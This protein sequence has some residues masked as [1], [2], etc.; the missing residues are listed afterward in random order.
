MRFGILG[1][2]EVA[3]DHRRIMIGGR[4]PR[5]LLAAL[6]CHPNRTVSTETLLEAV[7][8]TA[9]PKTAGKNLQV[10][11]HKLR[12]VLGHERLEHHA[13]G[14]AAVVAHGELDAAEFER[15]VQHGRIADD[16]GDHDR[17]RQLY[18]RALGC[19]RGEHPL[20]GVGDTPVLQLHVERLRDLRHT[21]LEK[22]CELDIRAGDSDRAL[23]DLAMLAAGNPLR[24]R[25]RLLQMAALY[26]TGRQAE[27][28]QVYLQLRRKLVAELGVEPGPQLQRLH[29]AILRGEAPTVWSAPHLAYPRR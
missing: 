15:L 13:D 9:P 16:E 5:S 25:T 18:A 3:D 6:L 14:Y 8:G 22:R 11:V 12:R 17:A 1:P 20:A 4:Q 2:V 24:E 27:A 19:W 28:L 23:T 10:Y 29:R 7:W 26:D 21:A